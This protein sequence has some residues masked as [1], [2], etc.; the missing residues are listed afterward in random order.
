MVTIN[1]SINRSKEITMENSRTRRNG[2]RP[3]SNAENASADVPNNRQDD[4]ASTEGDGQAP[5]SS[6]VLAAA[7]RR[8]KRR[9]FRAV[10]AAAHTRNAANASPI[11][12][13]RHPLSATESEDDGRS[14][15]TF[16]SQPN[17][18]STLRPLSSMGETSEF[19]RTPSRH[20]RSQ[21]YIPP[22]IVPGAVS[23][24]SRPIGDVPEWVSRVERMPPNPG[25]VQR[26]SRAPSEA[27]SSNGS[28]YFVPQSPGGST[29]LSTT[30]RS[31]RGGSSLLD[32]SSHHNPLDSS[33]H[34][35]RGRP[36]TL[37]RLSRQSTNFIRGSVRN[38]FI[39]L[40]RS[41]NLPEAEAL[42]T[43]KVVYAEVIEDGEHIAQ[44]CSLELL[45]Y[46][47]F[48]L[49]IGIYVGRITAP[50]AI[51]AGEGW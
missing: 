7:G 14:E 9:L 47:I 34:H 43:E 41:S 19:Q 49:L 37:R 45:L 40:R 1:Q 38:L 10:R 22:N 11:P 8:E 25:P 29:R 36:G 39:S 20:P 50:V 4:D 24:R 21:D 23:T 28:G 2:Q 17:D 15:D 32:R 46:S 35:R 44:A 42:D 5:L 13:M 31:F 27:S 3:E 51:L 6:A 18:T 48:L 26:H 16:A 33:S 12:P 30:D